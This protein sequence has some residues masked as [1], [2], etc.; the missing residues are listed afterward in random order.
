MTTDIVE[1]ELVGKKRVRHLDELHENG[2]M[3]RCR[4]WVS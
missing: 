4:L 3:S 1:L 2:L